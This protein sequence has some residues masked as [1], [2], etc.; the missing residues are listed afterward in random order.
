EA[1]EMNSLH[2][3]SNAEWREV[4]PLL[5]KAITQLNAADRAAILL[6]FFERRD[7]RSVGRDL[8]AHEDAARMRVN[9]A[10]E[11]LQAL[12]KAE[13]VTLSTAALASVLTAQAVTAAPAG[14]AVA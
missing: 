10:V 6:R 4:A 3:V 1:V 11:K 9:R 13:G 2:D 8:G 7:F 12:L 5:D 14:L